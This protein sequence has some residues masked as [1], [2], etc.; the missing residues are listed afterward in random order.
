MEEGHSAPATEE[1]TANPEAAVA[2]ESAHHP[3]KAAEAVKGGLTN[4][5][6]QA[7]AAASA[8][9]LTGEAETAAEATVQEVAKAARAGEDT[10]LTCS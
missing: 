5:K 8:H 4:I 10:T 2:M 9:G 3:T 7:A 1:D 6:A